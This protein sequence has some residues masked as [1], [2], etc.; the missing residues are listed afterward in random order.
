MTEK[1]R[2]RR[3][4][5]QT[6]IAIGTVFLTV[7]AVTIMALTSCGKAPPLLAEVTEPGVPV[8]KDWAVIASGA[9]ASAGLDFAL[10]I[11]TDGLLKIEGDAPDTNTRNRAFEIAT[12]AVLDDPAHVGK[13]IAFENA[14]KVAGQSVLSVPDAARA[15][16]NAPAAQAC[17]TAYDTLLNG[18]VINFESARAVLAE[19]SKP[20]LDAL[21][22]VTIRCATYKIEL[23]GHTDAQGDETANQALS[24]RRAQSVAD[25]LVSKSV[26][27]SQLGVMGLGET[28]PIDRSGSSEADARN[29]R[30]EFAVVE[31]GE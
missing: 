1:K 7:A 28:M 29:R 20:L 17:Q 12:G 22:A 30:I 5:F 15:L 3:K 25:Y 19:E 27:A 16:G 9:L 21:A 31:S 26:P 11:F 23:R 10:P 2:Q 18:R 14:I 13:V 24:E 8:E 6:G 4:A